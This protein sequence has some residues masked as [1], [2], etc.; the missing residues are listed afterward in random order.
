[1]IGTGN[2]LYLALLYFPVLLRH[3]Y[4]ELITVV[5]HLMAVAAAAH[6]AAVAAV[7]HV[8]VEVVAAVVEVVISKLLHI[9]KYLLIRCVFF[10]HLHAV[11]KTHIRHV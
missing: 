9:L 11:F 7:V 1:M 8:G 5:M 3:W 2:I 10:K 6:A 4:K